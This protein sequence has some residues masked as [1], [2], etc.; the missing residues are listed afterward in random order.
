MQLIQFDMKSPDSVLMALF[1]FVQLVKSLKMTFYFISETLVG[2]M[3][4]VDEIINLAH[5]QFK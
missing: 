1:L 3:I 4:I 2:G 5:T